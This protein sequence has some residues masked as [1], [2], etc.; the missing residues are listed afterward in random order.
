M[1]LAWT[2]LLAVLFA[3][4]LLWRRRPRRQ[5]RRALR[6]LSRDL[7]GSR[8][9]A[10]AAC[11]EIRRWLRVGFGTGQLQAVPMGKLRQARWQG[12][13]TRLGHCCFSGAAPSAGELDALIH[14]ARTWLNTSAADS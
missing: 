11:F 2:I 10:R 9:E 14:E 6:R 7:R 1:L 13:V 4:G 3:S 5:A 12:Y 8:V